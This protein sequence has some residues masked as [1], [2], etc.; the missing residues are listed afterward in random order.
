MKYTNYKTHKKKL[1]LTKNIAKK[2][3][4]NDNKHTQ[5]HTQ[6]QKQQK[7]KTYKTPKH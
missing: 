5:T 1:N 6:Q 4:N 3:N 2:Q 7:Q